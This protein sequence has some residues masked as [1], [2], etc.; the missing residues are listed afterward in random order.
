MKN[1][2]KYLVNAFF[3]VLLFGGCSQGIE[4]ITS[5]GEPK[6]GQFF[7][8]RI[9]TGNH[10]ADFNN[11]IPVHNDALNFI[12]RFDSSAIYETA[13]PSNQS[14]INKLYGFADNGAEHH[15][16]SARIG[17]NWND[18]FL[19]LHAYVYN[20]GVLT[21]Q[22]ICAVEIGTDIN[23]SISVSHDL[24][25][26]RVNTSTINVSRSANTHTGDGYKLYPFFGGDETAPHDIRIW[27]KEL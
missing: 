26:F 25:I 21:T 16:Y 23:C 1:K 14:D 19:R 5:F 13:D 9:R 27:I 11:Y 15:Q 4:A 2:M 22:E 6:A 8:Y 10:S 20:A 7:E 12:V 24:Y 18:G 17:W 3:I